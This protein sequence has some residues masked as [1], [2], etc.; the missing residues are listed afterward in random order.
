MTEK[1]TPLMKSILLYVVVGFLASCSAPDEEVASRIHAFMEESGTLGLAVAVVKEGRIVYTGSFGQRSTENEVP[2]QDGDVFRIASIS[3]SFATSALMKLVEEGNISLDDE[4]SDLAGFTIR[5]P[6]Y[7]DI[8]ITV[9]MVLS[10]SSS[11][12]DSQGYFDLDVLNPATNPDYGKCYNDYAPGT[13]YDYCNLGFNTLGAIIEKISGVRFDTYVRDVVIRPLN[14]AASYNV[15]DLPDATFVPLYHPDT[16]GA[17]ET[18]KIGFRHSQGVYD[19]PA[20]RI[21]A[22]YVMGYSTPMFSPTGGM[23]ISAIDLARYMT[24]HMYYGLDPATGVRIIAQEHSELMQTPVVEVNESN[25]YGL[26]LKRTTNLIPGE[27]MVG[28]TGSA[29]GLYSA[30]FFEP[31]KKFGFVVMTNGTTPDYATYVDDFA[32][33]QRDVVRILYEVFM[34]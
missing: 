27:E 15:D 25:H 5:N 22:G 4:M 19:S 18:G 17:S 12:N 28:H 14:L 32:P 29:Y 7:P 1:T 30:M 16:T 26:A 21:D 11:L 34:Q 8:P 31:E 3:K 23:K 24:V 10:H 2:L 13:Q 9:K 33:V 6:L 20:P